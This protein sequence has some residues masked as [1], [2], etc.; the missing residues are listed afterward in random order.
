MKSPS[1]KWQMPSYTDAKPATPRCQH[2][3]YAAI[4]E[5]AGWLKKNPDDSLIKISELAVENTEPKA[6]IKVIKDLILPKG[7]QQ[8]FQPKS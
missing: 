6:E 8:C 4:A 2:P 3:E 1:S 7:S 5:K